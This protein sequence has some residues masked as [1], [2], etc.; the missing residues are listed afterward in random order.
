MKFSHALSKMANE[1]GVMCRDGLEGGV[2]LIS[3]YRIKKED[4]KRMYGIERDLVVTRAYY[5]LKHDC[6]LEAYSF[7]N[8]DYFSDWEVLTSYSVAP[9][10]ERRSAIVEVSSMMEQQFLELSNRF[11]LDAQFIFST[12]Y[13]NIKT[14]LIA[15]ELVPEYTQ[16]GCID[17]VIITYFEGS[18]SIK[19]DVNPSAAAVAANRVEKYGKQ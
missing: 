7:T 13:D 1:G 3:G 10:A 15:S 18:D 14:Y 2:C 16:E 6:T 11:G 9:T 4:A 8:E 19:I 17:T 5:L 12:D